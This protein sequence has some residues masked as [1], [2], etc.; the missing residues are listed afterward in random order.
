MGEFDEFGG[1]ESNAEDLNATLASTGALVAGFDGELR[2]MSGSLAATGLPHLDSGT[3][4]QGGR[5][6][7]LLRCGHGAAV[8][9]GR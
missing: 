7:I 3:T 6:R 2:R 9:S 4:R 5:R 1:L 8:C